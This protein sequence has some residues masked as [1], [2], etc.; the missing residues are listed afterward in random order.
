MAQVRVLLV[1]MEEIE[2]NDATVADVTAYPAMF[3]QFLCFLSALF[4]PLIDEPVIS[5]PDVLLKPPMVR[6]MHAAVG[7][8]R[9]FKQAVDNAPNTLIT[10]R[11]T[12]FNLFK[13]LCKF[14]G[15][16]KSVS[17]H[18]LE[19]LRPDMIQKCRSGKLHHGKG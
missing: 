3:R 1:F 14:F 13:L 10:R 15:G 4:T 11:V 6:A 2:K 12:L 18:K 5:P 16:V 8:T 17:A 7:I 19:P 9:G